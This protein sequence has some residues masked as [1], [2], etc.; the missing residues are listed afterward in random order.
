MDC[1]FE[2]RKLELLCKEVLAIFGTKYSNYGPH[3]ARQLKTGKRPTCR[4][5]F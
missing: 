4:A 2:S 5:C 1:H 3:G